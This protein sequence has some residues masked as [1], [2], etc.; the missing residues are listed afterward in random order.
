M[1]FGRELRGC[2]RETAVDGVRREMQREGMG[3][4]GWGELFF[5]LAWSLWMA[6]FLWAGCLGWPVLGLL[7]LTFDV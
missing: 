1:V 2:V 7:G 5:L 4:E 6:S 3:R